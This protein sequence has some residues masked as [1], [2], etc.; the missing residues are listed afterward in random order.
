MDPKDD[1][2]KRRS[3][4]DAFDDIFRQMGV[5]PDEFER[6]FHDMHKQ[7]IDAMRQGM[8]EPGRHIVHGF[9]VKFGPDGK[10]RIESFGNRPT[11]PEGGLATTISDEREPL[12]DIIEGDMD[13]AVTMEIPGVSKSD[14]DVAAKPESLE[15]SV[16]TEKRKYHKIVR[17]PAKIE[18]DSTKA[19][20]NNGV[21]DIQMKKVEKGEPAHRVPVE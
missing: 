14:I 10:P 2:R 13:I 11:R 7:L 4:F 6:M 1:P 5:D 12:T 17:L 3:P 19:T 18:V 9:S 21:L 20:Y 16:D 15:I 8:P